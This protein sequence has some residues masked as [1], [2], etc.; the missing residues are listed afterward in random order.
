MVYK[1]KKRTLWPVLWQL[2]ALIATN[3]TSKIELIVI[4]SNTGPKAQSPFTQKTFVFV[5]LLKE[6]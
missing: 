5:Y 1:K 3:D 2:D 4:D 6:N